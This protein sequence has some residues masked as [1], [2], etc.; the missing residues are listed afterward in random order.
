M[1]SRGR[2][3]WMLR[4]LMPSSESVRAATVVWALLVGVVYLSK[5]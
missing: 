3:M 2:E 4:V 5:R 1:S